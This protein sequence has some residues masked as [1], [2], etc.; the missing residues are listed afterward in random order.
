MAAEGVVDRSQPLHIDGDH[1]H[2]LGLAGVAAE[3]ARQPLAE[4]GA[5]GESGH[6]IEVREEADR[7]LLVQVLQREGQVG[8]DLLQHPHLLLAEPAR[9]GAPHREGPDGS[10]VD[11]KRNRGQRADAKRLHRGAETQGT[12]HLRHIVADGH[13]ARAQRPDGDALARLAPAAVV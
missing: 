12:Y 5:L 13:L 7:V 11:E 3:R 8:G 6:R 1:H 2:L 4:E 10:M 9:L